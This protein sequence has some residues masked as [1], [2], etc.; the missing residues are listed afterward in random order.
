MK[1]KKLALFCILFAASIYANA[2]SVAFQIVQHGDS[3]IKDS[4]YVVEEALFEFFFNKGIVIS[5]SPIIISDDYEKDESFFMK[6]LDEADEGGV[7]YFIEFTAEYDSTKSSNPDLALLENVKSISWKLI[8]VKES[9][10]LGSG[11][12]SP[13]NNG[14][15]KNAQKGLSDFTFLLAEDIYKIIRG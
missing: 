1:V 3:T 15:I 12:K 8:E 5:N 10:V 11:K 6:S 7:K 13:S 9:K 14:R 2:V 4:S